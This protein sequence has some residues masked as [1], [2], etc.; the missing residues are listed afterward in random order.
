MT[1]P[2]DVVPL[3]V[4]RLTFASSEIIHTPER[5]GG[6]IFAM[7][8]QRRSICSVA[9]WPRLSFQTAQGATQKCGTFLFTRI[10][11]ERLFIDGTHGDG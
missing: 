5:A 7:A 2:K 6:F 11:C 10:D 4:Q 9:L 8:S 3:H 1:K